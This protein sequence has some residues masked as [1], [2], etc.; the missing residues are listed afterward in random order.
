MFC[1]GGKHLKAELHCSCQEGF[2]FPSGIGCRF[3]SWQTCATSTTSTGLS[4]ENS[5]CLTLEKG[6]VLQASVSGTEHLNL[7]GIAAIFSILDAKLQRFARKERSYCGHT[8]VTVKAFSLL[9]LLV[10]MYESV[11][12]MLIPG[13]SCGRPSRP[14][15]SVV[16][17][18]SRVLQAKCGEMLAGRQHR[19]LPVGGLDRAQCQESLRWPKPSLEKPLK[20]T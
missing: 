8:T 9:S 7:R 16:R 19:S 13:T 6:C 1:I 10:R 18:I 17:S 12:A 11:L 5:P 20:R 3:Q 2:P 15:F 4:Y 14:C